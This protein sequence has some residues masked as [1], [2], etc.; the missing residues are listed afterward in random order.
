MEL[1]SVL[2]DNYHVFE[3]FG[4]QFKLLACRELRR[5]EPGLV[6]RGNRPERFQVPSLRA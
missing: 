4:L 2:Q 1:T 5:P 6:R 3:L